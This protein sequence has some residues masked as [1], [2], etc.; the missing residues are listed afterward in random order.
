MESRFNP[1]FALYGAVTVA[2]VVSRQVRPD[3]PLPGRFQPLPD[4]AGVPLPIEHRFGRRADGAAACRAY[5]ARSLV[6]S[7]AEMTDS[8]DCPPFSPRQDALFSRGKQDRASLQ[9]HVH[10]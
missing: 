2:I 10:R 7:M 4:R 3:V 9:A 1:S 8:V 6:A 5:K